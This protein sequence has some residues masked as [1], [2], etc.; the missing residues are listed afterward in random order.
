MA[1]DA[2]TGMEFLH[3][4]KV[5][6]RDLKSKNLLVDRH[7]NVLVCDYGVSKIVSE[8]KNVEDGPIGTPSYM[9]PEIFNNESFTEKADVY[10]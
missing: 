7:Q 2:A 5:V 3:S 4:V 9:A 6:H 8:H 10:R 1:I